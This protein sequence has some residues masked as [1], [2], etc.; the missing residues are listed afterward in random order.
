MQAVHTEPNTESADLDKHRLVA[1]LL[2]LLIASDPF[3]INDP[4]L[5]SARHQARVLLRRHLGGE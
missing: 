5:I 3:G 4:D 1:A 2:D